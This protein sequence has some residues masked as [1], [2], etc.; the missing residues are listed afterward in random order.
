MRIKIGELVPFRKESCSRFSEE[1]S[2]PSFSFGIVV[3]FDHSVV[4]V[5]YMQQLAFPKRSD[6]ERFIAEQERIE[7]D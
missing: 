7:E 2:K 3:S 6:V 4:C 5:S 1:V